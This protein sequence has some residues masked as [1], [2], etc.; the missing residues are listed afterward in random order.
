MKPIPLRRMVLLLPLLS[1]RPAERQASAPQGTAP[2]E[3]DIRQAA[4]VAMASAPWDSAPGGSDPLCS[5]QTPCDTIMVEPKLVDLPPQPPAFFVPDR[6]EGA[7]L[8]SPEDLGAAPLPGRVLVLAT[9]QDCSARRGVPGWTRARVAC[10]ALGIAGRETAHADAM[11]FALLI[12]TTARGLGWPRVR[13][14]RPRDSWRGRLL[15]NA[16]N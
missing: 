14:T 13:V 9:W 11:T 3:M 16:G 12:L 7:A 2:T 15:S 8:L 10:V 5:A 1:C 6:R 4:L